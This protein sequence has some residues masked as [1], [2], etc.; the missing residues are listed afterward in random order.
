MNNKN[1]TRVQQ[2][3]SALLFVAVLISLGWLSTR[4]KME[5]DWTVGNRNTLTAP[6]Q[7]LL[8]SMADPIKFIAFVYPSADI[9]REVESQIQRYQRF[10]KDV[11][12]EFI[13]PSTQ[14]QKVK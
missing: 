1:Q 3:T 13:D 10:K 6:S 4:F 7:K 5:A 2:I 11:S 8:G 14:P 12:L 9:R